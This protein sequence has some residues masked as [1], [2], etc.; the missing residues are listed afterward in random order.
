MP[1]SPSSRTAGQT[2]EEGLRQRIA[3]LEAY[4]GTLEGELDETSRG[5]VA[6]TMELEDARE[7]YRYL[8]ENSVEGIVITDETTRIVEVN[9]A[10]EAI[11]GY[12]AEE[13]VGRNTTLL[14]SDWHDKPF[15]E[16]MWA[17]IRA[18][19]V[20]QG[21]IIDRRANGEAYVQWLTICEVRDDDNRV[22]NYLGIIDDITAKKESEK[23]IH[24]LAYYDHLTQLPNRTLLHD[25]LGQALRTARRDG[26]RLAVLFIDLDNFKNI[27]DTLGHLVGDK[28]LIEVAGVLLGKVRERDTV[29]RLGGDEFIILLEELH[30][31]QDASRVAKAILE[32]MAEPFRINGNEVFSG[33]S[34]GIAVFPEDGA[35]AATLVKH[36]DTAM[37]SAK[38]QGKNDF[39]FFTDDMNIR[40]F[41]R[42]R[43][44]NEL[45]TAAEQ[46]QFLLHYQPKL[47]LASGAITGMEALIRWRHPL[48]GLVPPY[49]FIPLA[50]ETGLIENIGDWVLREGLR[51]LREWRDA[52]LNPPP[53]A[54]NLSARQLRSKPLAAQID[55][56]LRHA[57]VGPELLHIELTETAVMSNPDEAIAFFRN[58][59]AAGHGISVDDF[60]TGYSSLSYL[61]RLPLDT[62]KIDQSFVHALTEGRDDQVI[63]E[64]IIAL[65][66]KMDLT[67][68]AEGVEK[69]EQACFLSAQGCD[70]VQ[71][72]Y[73]HRPLPPAEMAALLAR[74]A[75]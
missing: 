54:V 14:K 9:A 19:G 23:K 61:S 4:V 68:V 33:A 74:P 12:R 44:E 3:E 38:E 28:F 8:F 25:R 40:A 62:V 48:L 63:V 11:T 29:A 16:A 34:I 53:L 1:P 15:Y 60:G 52:G 57:G 64:A 21:E 47:D 71:G 72:Y 55:K 32:A 41:E 39:R 18:T 49:K 5:L 46:E 36:A 43:L 65:A 67:V 22:R 51:Q 7:R 26:H 27:N 35:D 66:H 24:Q 30:D 70:E 6:L 10:F 50:E 45:R 58:L 31:S 69:R 20:W 73:F 42:V 17:Q 13:V 75:Q 59:K 37:Y 2:P 56:H